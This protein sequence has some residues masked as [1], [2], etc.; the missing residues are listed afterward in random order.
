MDETPFYV[1]SLPG[2]TLE[3]VGTKQIDIVTTGHE[4][5]TNI[6]CHYLYCL[7]NNAAYIRNLKNFIKRA[8]MCDTT[9]LT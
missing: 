7:W 8:E 5:K 3:E 1:D 6:S 4:K 2:I 9:R